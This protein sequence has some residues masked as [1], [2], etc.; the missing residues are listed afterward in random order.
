MDNKTDDD[1][2][3]KVLKPC[4]DC[5]GTGKV[6][7]REND[8]GWEGLTGPPVWRQLVCAKCLGFGFVG[9]T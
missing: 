7:I 9:L 8:R 5:K 2:K 4:P 3:G 6:S 1:V